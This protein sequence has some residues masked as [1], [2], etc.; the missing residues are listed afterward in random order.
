MTEEGCSLL[1]GILDPRS[2][3]WSAVFACRCGIALIFFSFYICAFLPEFD[4]CSFSV[5]WILNICVASDWF[6][7]PNNFFDWLISFCL[8]LYSHIY[9]NILENLN[10]VHFI[11]TT[12]NISGEGIKKINRTRL[13]GFV[14]LTGLKYICRN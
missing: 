5:Y 9:K 4:S 13:K 6:T 7:L 14:N 3:D 8:I 1:A 12:V 11:I 10:L 2:R